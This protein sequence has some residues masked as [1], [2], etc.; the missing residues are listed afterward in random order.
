MIGSSSTGYGATR[1]AGFS[2]RTAYQLLR[3][4]P[5]QAHPALSSIHCLGYREAK[6]PEV[7]AI[8]Q[9]CLPIKNGGRTRII[10]GQRVSNNMCSSIG[11]TAMRGCSRRW[12]VR[13]LRE[14]IGSKRVVGTRQRQLERHQ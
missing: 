7:T 10:L 4:R 1:S 14:R 8:C 11:A 6:R 2:K 12:K 9:G 13:R 5:I 3:G